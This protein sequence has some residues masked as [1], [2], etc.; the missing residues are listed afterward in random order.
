MINLTKTLSPLLW[1]VLL[2][3][4][5]YAIDVDKQLHLGVSVAIGSSV[6]YF[7]GDSNVAM[8]TCSIVGLSKEIY[9]EYDYG[10]FDGEDLAYDLIGCALG[11]YILPPTINLIFNEDNV[12]VSYTYKF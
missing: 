11:S 1:G 6:T 9:D 3:A 5:S 4:P 7:T 2:S 10:G 8:M 12:G